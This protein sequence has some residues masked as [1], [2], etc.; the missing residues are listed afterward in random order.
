MGS[1]AV[2]GRVC[3]QGGT[4]APTALRAPPPPITHSHRAE[5]N[6]SKNSFAIPENVNPAE[7][8]SLPLDSHEVPH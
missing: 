7:K 5:E 4:R 2:P 1:P 8:V 3:R 6:S